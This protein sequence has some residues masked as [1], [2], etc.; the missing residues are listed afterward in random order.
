MCREK[1]DG[2]GIP[3]RGEV[4][5]NYIGQPASFWSSTTMKS[6]RNFVVGFHRHFLPRC[7]RGRRGARCPV[8]ISSVI[9]AKNQTRSFEQV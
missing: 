4:I 2:L 9:R 1:D 5:L 3:V 6:R 8:E 7:V